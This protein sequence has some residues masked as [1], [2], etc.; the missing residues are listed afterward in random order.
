MS[1][2]WG[3]KFYIPNNLPGDAA[4]FDQIDTF[5]IAKFKEYPKKTKLPSSI[6]K[7]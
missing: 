6:G 3:P 2:W 5:R 1:A 7:L 4:A